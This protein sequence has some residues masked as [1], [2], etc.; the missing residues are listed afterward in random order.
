MAAG[1]PRVA[2]ISLTLS[3][4]CGVAACQA[5]GQH[6]PDAPWPQSQPPSKKSDVL[7]EAQT[8]SAIDTL[9]HSSE[10][11]PSSPFLSS[12]NNSGQKSSKTIFTKYLYASSKSRQ[13]GYRPLASGSTLGRATFAASRS[14]V[15]R[16]G[17]G[18]SR[19]NTTYLLRAL[20]SVAADTAS[21]PYWRRSRAEPLSDFG[22]TVGNDAGMNLLHEFEPNLQQLMKSHA[23][24][25]VARIAEQ[26]SRR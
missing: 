7:L 26:I 18:K 14:L 19:L 17:S 12:L 10:L 23:P 24:K 2:V 4:V 13:A 1:I 6:L 3:V 16:D 9:P 8:R 11:A 20:T 22:S 25:I 21:R 5:V 15:A